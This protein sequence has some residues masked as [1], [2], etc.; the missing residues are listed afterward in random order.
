VW[1]PPETFASARRIAE[2]ALPGVSFR[3]HLLWRY[4]LRWTKPR[5]A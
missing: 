4:S 1:P 2:C 3:R 5:A